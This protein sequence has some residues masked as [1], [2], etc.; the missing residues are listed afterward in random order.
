MS[1]TF[2][3]LSHPQ[4]AIDPNVDIPDWPLNTVGQG[5]VQTLAQSGT[6]RGIDVVI[7]SQERK[8]IDTAAPL[9]AA[10]GCP[11]VSRSLMHENDRSAT[12]FLPVDEF[13]AVAD[14][15]FDR[16]DDSIRGWE[17]ARDAQA[18]I[19]GQVN[20]CLA[21]HT[22]GDVL[23]VGHGGVGTLLYCHF[24]GVPISR[25][26]DQLNGGGCYYACDG[27]DWRPRFGWRAMEHLSDGKTQGY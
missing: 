17:T 13:E 18:R 27:P 5:R 15:F 11:L 23:F 8:A 19:V 1:R 21:E 12:G 20:D 22:K 10:L 2:L 16:P 6:L 14:Q 7:S 24:A 3:Y 26:H 9:A 4:V 25:E